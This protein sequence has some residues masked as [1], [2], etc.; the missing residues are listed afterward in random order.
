MVPSCMKSR[1]AL[2]TGDLEPR[3][4]GLWWILQEE[5][6]GYAP[7]P[8]PDRGLLIRWCELPSGFHSDVAVV[9][10]PGLSVLGALEP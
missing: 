1:S 8:L 7:F 2:G 5:T 4:P 6:S 9:S 10:S 3:F